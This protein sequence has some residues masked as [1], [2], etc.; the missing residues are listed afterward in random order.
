MPVRGLFWAITFEPIELQS[1]ATMQ[2]VAFVMLFKFVLNGFSV[3]SIFFIKNEKKAIFLVKNWTKLVQ[4]GPNNAL[5]F[6][7]KIINFREI[8]L[9]Y[10]KSY[11]LHGH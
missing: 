7:I 2:N 8:F 9:G 6:F 10:K 1:S 4:N 11:I 3:K 5:S